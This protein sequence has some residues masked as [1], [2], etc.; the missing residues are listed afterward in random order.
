LESLARWKVLPVG[1]SCPLESL[2]R[3]KVLPVGKSCPLESLA[4]WKVLP[5]GK[6]C[7]LESRF[8]QKNTYPRARRDKSRL[9]NF[10]IYFGRKS[11]EKPLISLILDAQF[12]KLG[13]FIVGKSKIVGSSKPAISLTL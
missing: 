7:P 2:A 6:S 4:R 3:W 1:K 5:V 13:A 11:L 10:P 12:V 9:Y 8:L